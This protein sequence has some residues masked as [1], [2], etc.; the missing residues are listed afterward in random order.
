VSTISNFTTP[1]TGQLNRKKE[2]QSNIR[3]QNEESSKAPVRKKNRYS[4]S[5]ITIVIAIAIA[6]AIE[7]EIEI[8]IRNRWKRNHQTAPQYG[9]MAIC[10]LFFI[11]FF[12]PAAGGR[13]GAEHLV[14][15]TFHTL[16]QETFTICGLGQG[17]VKTSGGTFRACRNSF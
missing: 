5:A 11:L 17:V 10:K 2:L 7:I 8:A 6:I 1:A 9:I 14:E 3:Q 15:H 4:P 16:K 12:Y 13:S